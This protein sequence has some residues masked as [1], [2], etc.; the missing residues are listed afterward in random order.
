MPTPLQKNIEN[1]PDKKAL[2]FT[3]FIDRVLKK[4]LRLSRSE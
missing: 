4:F 2:P 1:D 3:D